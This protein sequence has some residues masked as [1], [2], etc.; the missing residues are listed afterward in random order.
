[1]RSATAWS[2]ACC[3]R[4][5]ED[6]LGGFVALAED[7]QGRLVARP[8]EVGDV[9]VTGFGHAQAVEAEQAHQRVG[10]TAVVL[11]GGEQV[12]ELVAVQ[13]R[14]GAGVS[15]RTADPRG[16]VAD[17][18]AFVF[19][20]PEPGAE[21]GHPPVQGARRRWRLLAFELAQVQ[22]EVGSS[23]ATEG[24]QLVG[25]AEGE[26]ALEVAPVGPAGLDRLEPRE[27]R[28]GP[29]GPLARI[30]LVVCQQCDG[31]VV[32]H[33]RLLDSA[34]GDRTPATHRSP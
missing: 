22:L 3:V 19:Q 18:D 17:G 7:P 11:G 30:L 33:D 31:G 8:A 10:V 23:H 14:L 28:A 21:G 9:D 25:S 5:F 32:V 20:P 12:G 1:V 6:R 29:P 4:G 24:M 2:T 26:P 34:R 27:E 13:P 16:R 15:L